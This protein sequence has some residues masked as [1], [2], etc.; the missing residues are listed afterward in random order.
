MFFVSMRNIGIEIFLS[1]SHLYGAYLGITLRR[2]RSAQPNKTAHIFSL[3]PC[4]CFPLDSSCGMPSAQVELAQDTHRCTHRRESQVETYAQV[5]FCHL[6]S[7]FVFSRHDYTTLFNSITFDGWIF[8]GVGYLCNS[9]GGY[10]KTHWITIS[11]KTRLSFF[12]AFS[13]L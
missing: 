12:S 8:L 10:V 11:R 9:L 4:W 2:R 6:H 7:C 1:L 13:Q 5:L 3:F